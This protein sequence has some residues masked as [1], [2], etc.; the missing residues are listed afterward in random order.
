[1]RIT[2]KM[3]WAA[4]GMYLVKFRLRACCSRAARAFTTLTLSCADVH[5]CLGWLRSSAC[6]HQLR[7]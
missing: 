3:A 1:M 6:V 5:S 2:V 4:F 7:L